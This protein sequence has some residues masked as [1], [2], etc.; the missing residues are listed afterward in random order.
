MRFPPVRYD[1]YVLISVGPTGNT[2]GLGRNLLPQNYLSTV[3]P[4]YLYH[5][6]GI[7]A[8][9]M[10]TRDANNNGQLD[11][12]YIARTRQD[13]ADIR[14]PNGEFVNQLPDELAPNGAGPIIYKSS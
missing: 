3:H 1:A 11:F 13:E 2:F 10:A 9:F 14:G 6:L 8:Y 5:A 12:D 4:N 7:A